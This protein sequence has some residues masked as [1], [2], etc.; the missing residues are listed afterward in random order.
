[1]AT[2]VSGTIADIQ[3]FPNN[4]G[5]IA[6]EIPLCEKSFCPVYRT[7]QALKALWNKVGQ[8]SAWSYVLES[9]PGLSLSEE[10]ALNRIMDFVENLGLFSLV[11]YLRRRTIAKGVFVVNL[12]D[13]NDHGLPLSRQQVVTT[14][15]CGLPP[16]TITSACSSIT[17]DY[18][19]ATPTY[20]EEIVSAQ[21]LDLATMS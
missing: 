5:I 8:N 9:S 21:N 16:Y 19:Y 6:E 10:S 12:N 1:M 13:Y 4:D 20:S 18:M 3:D 15:S 17:V 7:M 11:S 2:E 14:F